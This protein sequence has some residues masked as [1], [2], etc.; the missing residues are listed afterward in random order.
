MRKDKDGICLNIGYGLSFGKNWIN[1]DSS[2]SLLI[3]KFP[4]IGKTIAKALKLPKWHNNV[5]YGNILAR[6]LLPKDTC[7]LIYMSHVLEHI[8]YDDA[9]LAMKNIY[10]FLSSKGIFRIIVPDLEICVGN[11][12]ERL[13]L[14]SHEAANLFMKE[15]GIGM[16]DSRKNILKRFKDAFANSRHQWMYDKYSLEMLLRETGFI[17]IKLSKYGEWSDP[18]FAEIEEGSRMVNSICFECKK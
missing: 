18:R 7:Q 11:Y 4:L 2:P 14:Q 16:V 15:L 1:I 12:I 8:P 6:R 13:L 3:T 5:I 10:I 9:R 17:E